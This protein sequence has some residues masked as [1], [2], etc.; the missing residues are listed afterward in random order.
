MRQYIQAIKSMFDNRELM[1]I[2]NKD[3]R[4]SGKYKWTIVNFKD[5]KNKENIEYSDELEEVLEVQK[6]DLKLENDQNEIEII[7]NLNDYIQRADYFC[8]FEI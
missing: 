2:Q 4:M 7:F 6:Q 5:L 3:F 8:M 1:W